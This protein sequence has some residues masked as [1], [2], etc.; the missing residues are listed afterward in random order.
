MVARANNMLWLAE[1][2]KIFFSET[3]ELTETKLKVNDHWNILY[4]VSVFYADRKS[5][6][7]TTAGH[8]LTLDPMRKVSQN[9]S[10]LKP[11]GQMKPNCPRMI[12]GRSCTKYKFFM[13]IQNPRWPPLQDID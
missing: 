2:S 8:R 10:S 12:I 9:A 3:N 4:Q 7:A 6:M 13:P 1:I 11:L 5:E